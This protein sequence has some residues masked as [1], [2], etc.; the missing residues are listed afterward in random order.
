MNVDTVSYAMV[1]NEAETGVTRALN[2]P[3]GTTATGGATITNV[4]N[5]IGTEY[6]DTLTGNNQDNV[7][8]GGAGR[9]TLDGA[10]NPTAATEAGVIPCPMQ[11]PT[12]GSGSR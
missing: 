9:D 2:D 10:G 11:V 3:G 5:I 1:E 12:V 4:E 6:D 8:E 7:I